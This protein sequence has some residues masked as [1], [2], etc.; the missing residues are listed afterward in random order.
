MYL[1]NFL[2][3]IICKSRILSIFYNF[4][5]LKTYLYDFKIIFVAEKQSWSIYDDGLN[6]KKYLNQKKKNFMCILK[7]PGFFQNQIVHFGSQFVWTSWC[8]Y[9]CSSNKII[10]TY[11]HGK[12]ED[13]EYTK[14]H[15]EKFISS[16]NK[17]DLIITSSSR[18]VKRLKSWGVPKTMICIVP[19]G[20]DVKTFI[21]LKKE[22][23]NFSYKK[24]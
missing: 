4:E 22:Q 6:L 14:M 2:K 20:V 9:I 1:R 10:V 13:D 5:I 12:P 15:I 11:Y 3:S 8:D 24:I 16:L 21:P 23:K 17:I 7:K 18:G 19:I